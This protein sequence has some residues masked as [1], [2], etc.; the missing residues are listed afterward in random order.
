M[1]S[2]AVLATMPPKVSASA[3]L[4]TGTRVGLNIYRC[5]GVHDHLNYQYP[6]GLQHAGHRRLG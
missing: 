3:Y 5:I 4:T 6:A 1:D 2:W